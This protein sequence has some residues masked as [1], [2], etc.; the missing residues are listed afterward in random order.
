MLWDIKSTRLVSKMVRK[1]MLANIRSRA[2]DTK[3][4]VW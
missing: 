1:N 4:R 3:A 2:L